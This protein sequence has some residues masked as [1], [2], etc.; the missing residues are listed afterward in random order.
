MEAVRASAIYDY[1]GK[2]RPSAVYDGRRLPRMYRLV[3]VGEGVPRTLGYIEP[4]E[5]LGLERKL[6][7]L[8]GVMGDASRRSE[9]R[10]NAIQARRVDVLRGPDRTPTEPPGDGAGGA[11]ADG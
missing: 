2:L 1:V 11:D 4:R 6:G 8:V 7:V 3:T 10:L 5:E 9:L